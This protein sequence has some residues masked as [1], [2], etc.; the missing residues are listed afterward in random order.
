MSPIDLLRVSEA[1]SG[2]VAAAKVRSS[3]RTV[4]MSPTPKRTRSEVHE[5][6]TGASSVVIRA[7]D[8][9]KIGLDP[10]KLD[11]SVPISTANGSSRA[12]QVTLDRLAVCTGYSVDGEVHTEFPADLALLERAE[13]VVEAPAALEIPD[14]DGCLPS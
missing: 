7:E 2:N 1:L 6:R 5:E 3:I 12:A 14:A 10:D 8:A 9:R 4:M 11:Y 13:P